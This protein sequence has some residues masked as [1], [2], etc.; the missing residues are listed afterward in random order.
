VKAGKTG[1]RVESVSRAKVL[2]ELHRNEADLIEFMRD[3]GFGSIE[4]LQIQNGVPV[5]AEQVRGKVKF[6]VASSNQQ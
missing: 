4:H 6:G 2:M 1:V 3:L 5:I